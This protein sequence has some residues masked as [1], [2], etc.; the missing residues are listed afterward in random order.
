[1]IFDKTGDRRGGERLE[2]VVTV[3]S[4]EKNRLFRLPALADCA[5]IRTVPMRL[6]TVLEDWES[7][8]SQRVSD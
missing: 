1:M 8:G 7:S 2:Q 6:M 3:K 4:G 5:S